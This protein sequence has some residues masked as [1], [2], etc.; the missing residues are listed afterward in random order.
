MK[1]EMQVQI[2]EIK[3][4]VEAYGKVE[5]KTEGTALRKTLYRMQVNYDRD[6]KG[7]VQQI[8]SKK[9]LMELAMEDF[10]E[11]DIDGDYY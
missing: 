11:I 9:D 7:W 10:P 2:N 5:K 1:K 3:E 6:P 8:Y 4:V